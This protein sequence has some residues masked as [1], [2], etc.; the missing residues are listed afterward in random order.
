LR[1]ERL[2]RRSFSEGGS[3]RRAIFSE[4]ERVTPRPSDRASDELVAITKAYD[5]VRELTPRVGKFPRPFRFLLGDRILNNVYDLLDLL[6]EAKYTRDK[7]GLLDRANIKLEQVRFQV[8]L[9]HDE[10]LMSTRQ[11][12]VVAR[13]VDEVGRLVGGWRKAGRR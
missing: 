2:V 6:V 5:L 7:W 3:E 11:Y 9:A 12:E 13:Q 4:G 1:R 10:R 8:R